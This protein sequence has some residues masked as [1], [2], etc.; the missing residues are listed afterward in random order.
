MRWNN[1]LDHLGN[2]PLARPNILLPPDLPLS[3]V[4]S[5][6]LLMM[7]VTTRLPLQVATRPLTEVGMAAMH[8][9][10]GM[11]VTRATHPQETEVRVGESYVLNHGYQTVLPGFFG[12]TSSQPQQP[13]YAQQQAPPRKSGPGMGTALLA[14]EFWFAV[15]H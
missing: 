12:R 8:L 1:L 5:I 6:A 13:V 9:L 4:I 10:V 14:G 2:I 11:V 15:Q 3:I 7:A